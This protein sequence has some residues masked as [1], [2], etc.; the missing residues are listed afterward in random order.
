MKSKE[1]QIE[2][3]KTLKKFIQPL[4]TATMCGLGIIDEYAEVCFESQ[5]VEHDPNLSV[6]SGAKF[7][8]EL[9]D[10]LFYMASWCTVYD[11]SFDIE[12]LVVLP[13][14]IEIWKRVQF[15]AGAHKKSYFHG[16]PLPKDEIYKKIQELLTIYSI[17]CKLNGLSIEHIFDLNVQK[18]Q[19]S[20][21]KSGAYNDKEF[22][23]RDV[24]EESKIFK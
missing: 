15:I 3:E 2:S 6:E 7:V 10:V 4:K 11:Y 17:V 8:E 9:G 18:L 16:K 21:M 23:G 22:L 14:D 19:G 5:D 24:E 13:T 12:S 20:R 1:F